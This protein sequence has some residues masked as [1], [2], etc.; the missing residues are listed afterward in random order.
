MIHRRGETGIRGAILGVQQALDSEEIPQ[1]TTL[2]LSHRTRRA[3]HPSTSTTTPP[4]RLVNAQRS[5]GRSEKV[6]KPSCP[7]PTAEAEAST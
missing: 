3:A 7:G 5:M 6:D 1:H 4:I 2:R